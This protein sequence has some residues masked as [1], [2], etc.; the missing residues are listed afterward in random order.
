MAN[1]YAYNRTYY[2]NLARVSFNGN[3]ARK[4]KTV[5]DYESEFDDDY[6]VTEYPEDD[7][8]EEA[9]NARPAEPEQRRET[10]SEYGTAAQRH[11][12]P[13]YSIRFNVFGVLVFS[14]AVA[15][16]LF[17]AFKMLE[18]Q[19]NLSQI[20]KQIKAAKNELNDVNALNASLMDELDTEIDRN[21]IY[22]VAVGKFGMVYPDRNQVVYY[23]PS[24]QG[25]VRQISLIP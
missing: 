1:K 21:Y 7:Y 2:E 9:V 23:T 16:L 17:S 18:V 12:K 11:V 3:A 19:S 6:D 22:S 10:K 20:E 14:M 8:E 15:A 13:R 4:L 5:E 24:E 25:Y